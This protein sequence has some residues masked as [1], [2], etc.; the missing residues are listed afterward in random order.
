MQAHGLAFSG[1]CGRSHDYDRR[2]EILFQ[3]FAR[4][5]AV[6]H[7]S[8]CTVSVGLCAPLVPIVDAPRTPRF[9]ASC[10]KPQRS[11]TLVSGLSPMRVPPYACVLIPMA[12]P[13]GAR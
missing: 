11:T 12:P 13:V 10:E 1:G 3:F 5:S 2:L 9:G 7:A 6:R 4:C 8:A